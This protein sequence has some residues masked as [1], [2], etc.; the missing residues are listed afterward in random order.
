M[1]LRAIVLVFALI[2]LLA[3]IGVIGMLFMHGAMMSAGLGT[4]MM[5]FCRCGATAHP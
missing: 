3:V 1:V 2:G 5:E 4:G